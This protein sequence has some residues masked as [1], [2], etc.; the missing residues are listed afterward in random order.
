MN[1]PIPEGDGGRLVTSP[2]TNAAGPRQSAAKPTDDDLRQK[3]L[4]VPW[5]W[6][7]YYAVR[8]LAGTLRGKL[9]D[10]GVKALRRGLQELA[11]ETVAEHIRTGKPV[12]QRLAMMSRGEMSGEMYAAAESR[13]GSSRNAAMGAGRPPQA[14]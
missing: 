3:P 5:T 2:P 11:K 8:Y 6:G 4:V 9:D 13:I 1:Q 10:V 7:D 14:L 12:P